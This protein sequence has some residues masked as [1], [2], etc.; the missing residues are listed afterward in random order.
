MLFLIELPLLRSPV[1]DT[2]HPAHDLQLSTRTVSKFGCTE[3]NI[4]LTETTSTR[5]TQ[6]RLVA[7]TYL[8]PSATTAQTD[9]WAS[10][11]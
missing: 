8:A 2:T 4:I 6:T 7:S 9:Q 3:P 5:S 10:L 1:P 11:W